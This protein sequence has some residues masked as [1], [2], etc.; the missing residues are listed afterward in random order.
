MKINKDVQTLKDING[1]TAHDNIRLYASDNT[2]E[3]SPVN[4]SNLFIE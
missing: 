3:A 4:L 1:L 2:E